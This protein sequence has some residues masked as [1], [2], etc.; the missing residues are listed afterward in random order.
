MTKAFELRFE[1]EIPSNATSSD[2]SAGF[3]LVFDDAEPVQSTGYDL[4][5]ADDPTA[6]QQQ[7]VLWAGKPVTVEAVKRVAAEQGVSHEAIMFAGTDMGRREAMAAKTAGGQTFLRVADAF[8]QIGDVVVASGARLV[9]RDDLAG[10]VHNYRRQRQE[11]LD[12]AEKGGDISYALGERGNRIYNGITDTVTKTASLGTAIGP[13]AVYS[14]IVA[15]TWEPYRRLWH[16]RHPRIRGVAGRGSVGAVKKLGQHLKSLQNKLPDM[17]NA[18]RDAE[19]DLR[20]INPF[21]VKDADDAELDR[22]GVNG[23]SGPRSA[24]E[25]TQAVAARNAE[26]VL[27]DPSVKSAF[28][29]KHG[30]EGYSQIV[31]AVKLQVGTPHGSKTIQ[32]RSSIVAGAHIAGKLSV[33]GAQTLDSIV[34]AAQDEHGFKDLAAANAELMDRHAADITAEMEVGLSAYSG[35]YWQR[36]HSDEAAGIQSHGQ[37]RRSGYFRVPSLAQQSMRRFFGSEVELADKPN[38]LAA[39]RETTRCRDCRPNAFGLPVATCRSL[40]AILRTR[41]RGS[42]S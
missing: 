36:Y 9:G 33:I 29:E 35:E 5:F 31:D 27:N 2:R 20:G 21:L 24:W 25:I 18:A 15:D 4:A 28:T 6:E 38:Y 19:V 40:L 1:D 11:F 23:Q 37:I 8:E 14:H 12:L 22:Q 16:C 3:D 34:A 10:Q 32:A 17:A 41:Y 26:V 13:T 30:R 39:K 42:F 7:K